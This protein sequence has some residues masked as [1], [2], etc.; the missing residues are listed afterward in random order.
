[1]AGG[2]SFFGGGGQALCSLGW[3]QALQDL[4]NSRLQVVNHHTQF[5]F[6]VILITSQSFGNTGQILA[7]FRNKA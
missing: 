7:Y 4:S 2:F 1:M 5:K 3:P 6:I